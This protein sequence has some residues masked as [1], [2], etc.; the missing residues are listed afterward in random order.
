MM[1]VHCFLLKVLRI[2]TRAL[3]YHDTA[4][5]AL[6]LCCLTRLKIEARLMCTANYTQA[7]ESQTL[8][9]SSLHPDRLLAIGCSVCASLFHLSVTCVQ[10]SRL[11]STPGLRAVAN[12]PIVS[13]LITSFMPSVILRIFLALLPNLLA[14]M[15]HVQ[16][17]TSLSQ[18]DFGVMRK[19]FIFQVSP[20]CPSLVR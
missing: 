3:A 17:M 14:F 15:S 7:T 20:Y 12:L 5:T 4:I 16:G 11:E 10:V 6:L 8:S 19:Y 9:S 13:G 18:I 1:A 2:T